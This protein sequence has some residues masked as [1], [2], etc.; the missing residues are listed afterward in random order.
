[1]R[2]ISGFLQI[3][4]LVVIAVSGY[5]IWYATW[6]PNPNDR[7]G[8][9]IAYYLPT[10]FKDWGCGKLNQ[11]FAT[12]APTVCSPAA[13]SGSAVPSPDAPTTTP[14]SGPESPTTPGGSGRL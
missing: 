3:I 13:G 7:V 1:M 10:P 12:N 2:T 6:G 14:N 11:R 5:W 9:T 8:T 4:G